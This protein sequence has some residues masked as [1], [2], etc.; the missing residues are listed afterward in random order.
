MTRLAALIGGLVAWL[1]GSVLRVRRAHVEAAMARA[2]IAQPS[3]T[4][5]AMYR[6]L[7]RGL[8]E[9][10]YAIV[11]P[12]RA[13]R[14]VAFDEADLERVRGSGGV[15]L[16]VA[17]TGNWDLVGIAAAQH[18]P[19]TVVTKRFSV[20]W[21]DRLWQGARAR[22]GVRLVTVGS[23][24]RAASAALGRGENV[25]MMIDQAPERSRAVTLVDFLGAPA[26]VDLA[27]ALVAMRA[28]R[29][30]ALV[31]PERVA[32]GTHRVR[33]DAFIE[34]PSRPSRRWAE[35]TM[36][37]LTRRLE[38]H[39]RRRPDQWLWMH[40]RWKGAPDRS[41]DFSKSSVILTS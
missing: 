5:R 40:R 21:L 18:L 33:I 8:C 28:R 10:L 22:R 30:I 20:A 4:A 12:A 36:A 29:P 37:T 2:D 15:V 3:R 31:I 9:L 16:A 41:G 25:A 24:A 11:R 26:V 17:H 1:V 19:L 32:D 6:S 39:V 35:G 34:S 14:E 23:A 13:F 27:P 7:G 38:R